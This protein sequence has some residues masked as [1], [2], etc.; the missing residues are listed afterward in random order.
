MAL[1]G[2]VKEIPLNLGSVTSTARSIVRVSHL[3]PDGQ[4]AIYVMLDFGRTDVGV[5]TKEI[6]RKAVVV[7]SVYRS[8]LIKQPGQPVVG[9][10]VF[11]LMQVA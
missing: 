8:W 9:N 2:V 11:V 3:I 10:I 1:S 4:I 7:V 6:T 5:R